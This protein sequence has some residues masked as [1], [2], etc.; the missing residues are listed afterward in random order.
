MSI[1]PNKF[2]SFALSRPKSISIPSFRSH[3]KRYI[4]IVN[5]VLWTQRTRIQRKCS[6]L[7][8][9]PVK[10]DEPSIE[11]QPGIT[12]TQLTSRKLNNDV[13]SLKFD[14][15]G[16]FL[17]VGCKNGSKL[18]YSMTESKNQ[19]YRQRNFW[20]ELTMSKKI[21]SLVWSKRKVK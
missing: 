18:L 13:L 2:P 15:E 19:G 17:A 7:S 8:R 11:T 9:P 5:V 4:N 1:H 21:Q 10:I 3:P 14:R 6:S 16:E 20:V 12:L